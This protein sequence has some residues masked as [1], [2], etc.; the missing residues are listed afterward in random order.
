YASEHART[1]PGFDEIDAL[2][3]PENWAQTIDEARVDQ[4]ETFEAL[5]LLDRESLWGPLVDL[6]S[7][8]ET[9]EALEKGSVLDTS[10]L[11]LIRRWLYATDSWIATP[12]ETIDGDHLRK[13]LSS[14][15]FLIDPK[16]P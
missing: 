10:R 2:Q 4:A 16:E 11:A 3:N 9:L 13:A 6:G 5:A 14:V 8:Y 1:E 12:K 7:P 15:E